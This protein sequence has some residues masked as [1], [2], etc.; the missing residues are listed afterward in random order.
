M[1]LGRVLNAYRSER[2]MSLRCLAKDIKTSPATLSRI[3]HGFPCDG[4][5][6]MKV[7]NWLTEKQ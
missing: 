2:R 5:T 1:N 4:E 6:L 7:F 3:E